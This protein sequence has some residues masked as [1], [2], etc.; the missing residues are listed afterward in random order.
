[1]DDVA[2]APVLSLEAQWALWVENYT[3]HLDQVPGLLEVIQASAIPLA[4]ARYDAVRVDVSRDG[5]PVPFRVDSIDDADD[6]WSAL[7]QYAENV[8]DLFERLGPH[9][10][11]PMPLV[12]RWRIGTETSGIRP[13]AN[14]RADA[15]AV[16]AWLVELVDWVGQLPELG[17]SEAFL[18]DRIRALRPRYGL[19]APAPRKRP[20]P[21]CHTCGEAEMVVVFSIAGRRLQRCPNCGE[22]G[23]P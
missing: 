2:E 12:A 16:V 10:L 4:A 21:V 3:W 22:E 23:S 1:M 9:T 14:V 7:V 18:F 8:A 6:L 15:F 11:A 17:D 13:G 19:W 5:A 20:A